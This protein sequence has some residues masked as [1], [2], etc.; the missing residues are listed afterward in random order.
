M[1]AINLLDHPI[2]VL[3]LAEAE[4]LDWHDFK[5][6]T[7]TKGVSVSRIVT[8]LIRHAVESK[9]SDIHIEPKGKETRV[10]YRI[11]GILRTLFTLPGYLH[12]ALVAHIKVLAHL[13]HDEMRLPQDGR[14]MHNIDGKKVDLN[15]S[16][17]PVVDDEKVVMSVLDASTGVPTLAGLGFRDAYRQALESELGKPNGIILLSGPA[18]SGKSTT[19]MAL[20]GMIVGKGKAVST[21]EDPVEYIMPGVKQSQI[22]P[23]TGFTFA[24]GLQALLRQDPHIIMLGDIGDRQVAE[25]A[26]HASLT[27]HLILGSIRTADALG[28]VS[29]LT[30]LGLEPFL[31]SDSLNLIVTQRLIRTICEDC[32]TDGEVQD[33]ALETVRD[34]LRGVPSAYLPTGVTIDCNLDFKKGKGCVRCSDTGYSGRTVIA[35]L[36]GVTPEMRK[37]MNA[38]FP[39]DQV[40]AEIQKQG[41]ITLRQDAMLKAVEGLTTVDEALRLTRE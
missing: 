30:D 11:D 27:G 22:R 6:G 29:H 28:V 18:G 31:L 40:K 23:E 10:R 15:V 16:T 4:P 26:T 39:I 7:V 32:K 8:A 5:I 20:L 37:L 1:S 19:H 21:L 3:E 13:K 2:P 14:F 9:A 38:G 36:I 35:E 41:W 25:L 33:G 24:S 12:T 34:V 17:L